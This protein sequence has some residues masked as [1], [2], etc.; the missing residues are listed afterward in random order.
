MPIGS[1]SSSES[2]YQLDHANPTTPAPNSEKK[3]ISSRPFRWKSPSDA[4]VVEPN[5]DPSPKNVTSSPTPS[6]SI[7]RRSCASGS[8]CWKGWPNTVMTKPARIRVRIG[9]ACHT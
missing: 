2:T 3:P 6:A 7:C 4:A 9:G 1:I 5:S 8:R